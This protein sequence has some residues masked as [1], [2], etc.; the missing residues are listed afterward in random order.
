MEFARRAREIHGIDP[1]I[2]EFPEGTKTSAEAAEAIGCAVE[3]IA[4]S[5]VFVADGQPVV[6]VASGGG[7]VDES[8]LAAVVGVDPASVRTA[9]PDEVREATGWSIG[10][11]PPFCH[12][13]DPPVYLD[14]TL[15]GFDTVWAAAGTPRA[16]FEVDPEDVIAHASADLAD[17]L[18]SD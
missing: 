3:R 8:K 12:D 7:R 6:V 13:G 1:E 10:G 2:R 15:A 17:V 11:V 9:D 18:A 16:V 4:A 14:E 5:L